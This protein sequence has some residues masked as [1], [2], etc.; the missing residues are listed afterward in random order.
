MFRPFT[1]SLAPEKPQA[2]AVEVRPALTMGILVKALEIWER[3]GDSNAPLWL[4]FTTPSD[5]LRAR[6]EIR[7]RYRIQTLTEFG[8][9]VM[10]YGEDADRLVFIIKQ[11]KANRTL[12][13]QTA[14]RLKHA[15]KK[16]KND[17][18]TVTITYLSADEAITAKRL[19]AHHYGLF[20]VIRDEAKLVVPKSSAEEFFVQI[21]AE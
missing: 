9:I 17:S 10:V 16:S 8:A 19:L 14:E 12:E 18:R 11:L 7:Q 13:I 20:D 15:L 21:L 4:N 2:A 6:E 3:D 1:K 5:A